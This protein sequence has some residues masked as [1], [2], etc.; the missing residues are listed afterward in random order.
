MSSAASSAAKHTPTAILTVNKRL[1]RKAIYL[2]YR[3]LQTVLAP[4]VLLYFVVRGMREPRYFAT[5]RQR[6]GELPALWQKTAPGAIWLHAVSVGEVLAAIPL[7]VELRHRLPRAPLYL[8][9]S[10]LAGHETAIKRLTELVDGAFYAPIDYVWAVRRV[11]RRLRPSVLVVLETEIWPN[12]FREVARSGAGVVLVNG[13]ISDRALPRY[14]RWRNFFGPVLSLCDQILTQSDE[15]RGRFVDVGAPPDHVATAG[16][17]KYDFT[18][19]ALVPDSPIRQFLEASS[20]PV[21]IAAS[22]STDGSIV[23]EDAVIVAHRELSHQG[24]R[25]ILAPRKPDRF[26]E[27]AAKLAASGLNWTRR[28]ALTEPSANVLLLDSVGELASLFPFAT[29]VFMGGTLAAIGGHN[30]LEPAVAGKPV[31]AGPHL[32]NFRDIERH[33]DAHTALL[34]ITRGEDLAAAIRAADPGLGERGRE[35]AKAETGAAQRIAEVV[36]A[37]HSAHYPTSRPAQ[38]GWAVLWALSRLWSYGSARDRRNK[39]ARIRKLPVPVISVG[40]ITAGGTGKTPM[41]IALLKALASEN[42]GILTRG[43]GRS[44]P[45]VVTVGTNQKAST[46]LIGDEPQLI[47]RATGAPMAIGADRFAAGM[48]LLQT[49]SPGLL[50]LDDGFQHLQLARDFDLVIID[51]L[52]PFGGGHLLP[53]GRLREPLEGLRRAHAFVITRSGDVANMQ[54]IERVLP[55]VPIFHGRTVAKHWRNSAGETI[56]LAHFAAF[57]SLAFCGL[58]NPQAFWTTLAGIG[59]TPVEKYTYDDHH[60][61]RPSEMIRLSRRARSI[62]A[63]FLLTTEKDAVNIAHPVDHLWWLEVELQID[64]MDELVSLIRKS[65]RH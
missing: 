52:N 12:M 18:L 50:I 15:M 33:F 14:Q 25:L 38:P 51:G 8:S 35:A 20:A 31:V 63:E 16:N 42:P 17:L 7:L 11:I 9:T 32:E 4:L 59:I 1:K 37:E 54:S 65:M 61:Y 49:E 43:H 21:W 27:V 47:Q 19:P 40:N 53:L 3:I 46:S 58:G 34:R 56:A 29:A 62:A 39:L 41:S 57:R 28:T 44:A 60:Q 22:T 2:L 13:R 26:A 48:R 24:W 30:V 23:E 55:G 36:V 5:L 6:M 64:R 10:T 45:G